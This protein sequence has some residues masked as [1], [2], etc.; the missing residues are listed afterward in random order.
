[1]TVR[2]RS[3]A[4]AIFLV[5]GA[6]SLVAAACGGDDDDD[7]AG[8]TATTA[9]PA[10]ASPTTAGTE[11]TTADT[12]A[13]ATSAATGST[14]PGGSGGSAGCPEIDD[15]I[16][17]DE[18]NGAGRF[19][20]D[21]TCA[22]ASP[23]KAEGDP[24]VIGFQNLE[25]DPNGS[26]PE[27]SLTAQAAVDY[28]NNELGGL[29]ADIQNGVPGRPIQLEVC[30]SVVSPDDSQRCANELLTDDPFMVFSSINF[31]GNQFPIY[32]AAN[33]PVVV[34][35]PITVGDFTSPGVYS[36]GAG[37][38]CLGV[39]TGLVEFVTTDLKAT[40]VAVPWADTPPGVVCYYDLENKPLEVLKGAT[41]GDSE[42]AGSLPDLEHMGVAIKP[43][44][45]DVTPQV[46]QVL[47][48]DPD[49]IMFS[50][51]GADC[52]N[53]VDGLG[54]LGWTPDQIPLVLSGACIDF[55]AMRDAGDLA[56]GIYFVGASGAVLNDPSTITN[57]R[58]KFEAENYQTKPVEYGL[59]QDELTKGFAT[60]SWSAL[61]SLWELS[62]N[63][64][65]GGG[66]LT[67]EA[68]SAAYAET[69]NQHLF[70]STPMSCSTA[71]APYVAV[72]NSEVSATQWNGSELEPVRERFSGI[73]LVAGTEL[74]PG[75]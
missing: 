10:S 2:S 50:A 71:P 72:C 59:A 69:D 58:D 12:G 41:P 14:E 3:R 28:I 66:E 5:A 6:L 45:P 4:R 25:G 37:G 70:G 54:R 22:A 18:G 17:A 65:V 7:T 20:S 13:P 34:I 35:T 26:F 74:K 32:A 48:F 43:A 56:K 19:I 29:G 8:T 47:D 46:T 39:H 40:R 63:I 38:G 16:D 51:Q 1:M 23:L 24:I 52:W 44:T 75:P 9:P 36:I 31:F 55:A 62:S 53:L 21:L 67:Q 42:R 68:I 15:S 33:M 49:A 30:K 57:A 73:G 61:L 27:F 11:T 64:V 60:Q